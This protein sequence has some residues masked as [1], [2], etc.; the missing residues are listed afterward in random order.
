M[1]D[2]I[3]E[4]R[5]TRYIDNK[6][7]AKLLGVSYRAFCKM[8]TNDMDVK[9]AMAECS[10]EIADTI[11]ASIYQKAMGYEAQEIEITAAYDKHGQA[12]NNKLEQHLVIKITTKHIPADMRA[13]EMALNKLDPAWADG[14][15]EVVIYDDIIDQDIGADTTSIPEALE[16]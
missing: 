4:Y 14:G 2:K 5:L 8:L 11:K 13:A 1:I 15:K 3:K 16:E 10:E 7:L 6:R 9:E 12:V